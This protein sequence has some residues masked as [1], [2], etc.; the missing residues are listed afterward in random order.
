M[1]GEITPD[2]GVPWFVDRTLKD[3]IYYTQQ[4]SL[5]L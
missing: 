1:Y 5:L 2:I 4:Q 3:V